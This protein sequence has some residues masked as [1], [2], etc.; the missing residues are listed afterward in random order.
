MAL[1]RKGALTP[2]RRAPAK[3]L[4]VGISEKAVLARPMPRM[5]TNN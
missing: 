3:K 5:E 4:S 1:T 2:G